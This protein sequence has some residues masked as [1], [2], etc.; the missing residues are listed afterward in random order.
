MIKEKAYAKVN[1]FLNV[2]GKR[3]D[4]F[5]DLEMVMAPLSLHDVLTFKLLEERTIIVNSNIDVVD[6]VEDNLI[7]KV[8]KFLQEEFNVFEGVEITLDKKIP[9][10]G[11]LAGGSA[12]AA[13]TFRGLN[14]LWNLELELDD[15]AKLGLEFGSDIPFCI[16]N[17]LAVAKGR[18]EELTFINTELNYH[19]LVVNPHIPISTKEVFTS[20]K[21]E[22][23][24]V[25]SIKGMLDGIK[26]NEFSIVK[27][28]LFNSLEPITFGLNPKVREVKNEIK[29]LGL[30]ATLMSGSGSTIF[31]I[32][33]SKK[34]IKSVQ[35][36]VCE[37]YYTNITKFH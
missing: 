8:A 33:N 1:L 37:L 27:K 19:V 30:D 23:I 31:S 32:S 24:G 29:D 25:K 2:I 14:K 13:A 36:E 35:N 12:D 21:T 18:G 9:V 6:N 26:S 3:I 16:Y 4:G 5:H 34:L 28:E 15:M 17:K 20:I 10:A 22:D 11:G 7:Y